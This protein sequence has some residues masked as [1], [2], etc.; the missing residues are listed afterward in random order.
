MKTIIRLAGITIVLLAGSNL[1]F[2]EPDSNDDSSQKAV[3]VTG[4]STG[5]GRKIT[6]VL[7]AD[8]YFVYAGARKQRDLD[9]LNEIANV[10]SIRLD[11]TIQEEIDAAVETVLDGGKG[12]YGLVNNAGVVLAA[13]LIEIDEQDFQFQM[14]VNL[15]GPYRVTKAFAPLIMESNGRITTISSINGIVSSSLF[16]PYS[17]SKHAMEAFT[18]ALADEMDSFGV[19]VSAIEP[20]T[21]SS[22]I[23]QNM[24]DRMEK[25]GQ[26]AEGSLFQ[27]EIEGALKWMTVNLAQSGDPMEVAVAV[28]QALFEE[29]PKRRYLV[30]PNQAQA[31][32]TIRAAIDKVAQLNQRHAFSF[33]RDEL[34]LML[35]K[36]L[37]ANP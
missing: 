28:R 11:V 3:L 26:S 14:D 19:Q 25:Q 17:M 27:K 9:A 2:A 12:L 30:V 21:Y 13:P 20:G 15:Y 5:I 22:R 6:E 7:A 4:A 36:A 35:D 24:V 37:Q 10:Q 1:S 18:D 31:R 34:V 16:G 8:G 23:G 29:N 33:D 32:G